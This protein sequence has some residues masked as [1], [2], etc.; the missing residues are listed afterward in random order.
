M[1]QVFYTAMLLFLLSL[2]S[3][4]YTPAVTDWR[5]RATA[6]NPSLLTATAWERYD[7]ATWVAQTMA[8]NAY[9]L[10]I[11]QVIFTVNGTIGVTTKVFASN[12]IIAN[13]ATVSGGYASTTTT[14]TTNA[15]NIEVETGGIFSINNNFAIAAGGLTPNLIVRNGGTLNL[16]TGASVRIFSSSNLW[17][18]IELF[19]TGSTVFINDWAD[20]AAF[21]RPSLITPNADGF[22][23][24]D[25]TYEQFPNSMAN[26]HYLV[27]APTISGTI[28]LCKNITCQL[29]VSNV[30]LYQ[31]VNGAGINNNYKI[32]IDNNFA[33]NGYYTDAVKTG[34]YDVEVKGNITTAA[35]YKFNIAEG[36][37][38]C[39]GSNNQNITEPNGG[40]ALIYHL[41]VAKTGTGIINCINNIKV[42][43]LTITS[44]IINA[45]GKLIDQLTENGL[46]YIS[47]AIWGK[48]R[49]IFSATTNTLSDSRALYP[50]GK[51]GDPI[52]IR[53]YKIAITAAPAGGAG[54]IQVE[55]INTN[56]SVNGLP[57]SAANSGSFGQIINRKNDDGYWA[58]DLF[59]SIGNSKTLTV[60]LITNETIQ[61]ATGTLAQLTQIDRVVLADSWKA[62]GTHVATTSSGGLITTSRTGLTF[63][64]GGA[65]YSIASNFTLLNFTNINNFTGVAKDFYNEI[66]YNLTGLLNVNK[67]TL[68][69]ADAT[70]NN[71]TTV[72]LLDNSIGAKTI[73]DVCTANMA[74]YRIAIYKNNGAIEYSNQIL[75]ARNITNTKIWYNAANSNLVI[76]KPSDVT[77]YNAAGNTVKSITNATV[78]HCSNLPNG[79]YIAQVKNAKAI[80]FIK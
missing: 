62:N 63:N 36:K 73:Q 79:V 39:S 48:Y 49:K 53:Q 44:G 25:I 68:Q 75:I 58:L 60:Q 23:F 51:T 8:P 24:G 30:Y 10:P 34:K 46:T 61:A 15:N 43:N 50:M 4:A 14:L 80:K 33:F 40:N 20:Y 17:N 7:G 31:D 67:V 13:G 5:T 78:I 65:Q 28:N 27:T 45:N 29:G 1:K 16:N 12:I 69:R 47:G 3:F 18:G 38:I 64:S 55:Y 70:Q 52:A 56:A 37:L 35:M 21:C 6:V 54:Y 22:L 26:V 19:E 41:E 11:G 76:N 74:Y 32:L 77:I 66:K 9:M 42:D 2:T 72:K 71:Y 57:L 59:N